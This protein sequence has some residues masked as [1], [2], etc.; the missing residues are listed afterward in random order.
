ME[1]E[2][3]Q[4]LAIKNPFAGIP[5]LTKGIAVLILLL[6]LAGNFFNVTPILALIPGTT[7]FSPYYVWNIITS[8]F[9][10]VSAIT[11]VINI[12]SILMFGKYLEPI[13]GSLEFLKFILAINFLSGIAVFLTM[14]FLYMP[15][16]EEALLYTY[17]WCGFSGVSMGFTVAL[18]QLMPDQDFNF[19]FIFPLKIKYMPGIFMLI[20]ILLGIFVSANP[21]LPHTLFGCFFSWLYLRF[22]Q[23]RS[24][25]S[26]GDYSDSFSFAFFFPEILQPFVAWICGR[27]F[28]VFKMC[29]I[30]SSQRSSHIIDAFDLDAQTTPMLPDSA[31]SERRRAKALRAIDKR[32]AQVKESG[33]QSNLASS[34]ISSSLINAPPA[35][36]V[37]RIS[38]TNPVQA[39][40]V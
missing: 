39:D 15:S 7:F 18:K 32:L 34:S 22:F 1:E 20:A 35:D 6:F 27:I 31:D 3:Q 38:E 16:Q 24:D 13:W 30:M 26:I 29:G 4:Y 11:L 17:Y 23:R 37:V 5:R 28:N 21:S 40:P 25:G 14:I 36:V 19:L 9:F 10:E 33:L 8:G 2:Q 12:V